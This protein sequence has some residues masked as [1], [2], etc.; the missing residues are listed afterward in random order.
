MTET[1]EKLEKR[2]A[3]LEREVQELPSNL[4]KQVI[5]A[6]KQTKYTIGGEKITL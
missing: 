2:V 6:Q 1:L 4:I 5:N 3:T